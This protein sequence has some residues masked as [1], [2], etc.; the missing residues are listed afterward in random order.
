MFALQTKCARVIDIATQ[1]SGYEAVA[2]ETQVWEHRIY[3]L[4]IVS[5][6]AHDWGKTLKWL[7]V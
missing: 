1:F 7:T 3:A 6:L 5:H 2:S 4:A